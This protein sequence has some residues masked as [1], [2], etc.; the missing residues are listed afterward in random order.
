[1][2]LGRARSGASSVEVS[3]LLGAPMPE[4]V[5]ELI[6]RGR[7]ADGS[8]LVSALGIRATRHHPR[9][10][11][12][13]VQVGSN[14]ADSGESGGVTMEPVV[15]LPRSWYPADS[16]DEWG[17]DVHLIELLTPRLRCVGM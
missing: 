14:R 13:A 1:M 17:R 16:V 4:H 5:M 7:L 6:H 8:A 11:R 15:R 3:Y 2:P 10:D 12:P 9:C